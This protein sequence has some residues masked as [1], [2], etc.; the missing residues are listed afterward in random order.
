MSWGQWMT[1]NEFENLVR[2]RH[3][4]AEPFDR[5]EFEGLVA[6]ATDRLRDARI[7]SLSLISRFD[8]AYNAAH[9]LALAALRAKGYRTDKR[10][11][12]FQCLPHTLETATEQV[13]LLSLCHDR[14]N[15]VEYEGAINI[16]EQLFSELL[17]A[18]EA[19]HTEL[20]GTIGQGEGS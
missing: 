1:L 17:A 6:S 19:L 20:V 18:A 2:I 14:R 12:V 5:V 11:L 10:Y 4:H 9:A 8:L 3:L 16:D 15:R 7:A 13:R